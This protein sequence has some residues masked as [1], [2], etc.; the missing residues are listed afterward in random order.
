MAIWI[1]VALF[2]VLGF[3]G[4]FINKVPGPICVVIGVLI[5]KV[6]KD[7]P[8]SWATIALIAVLAIFS[9]F[10]AKKLV[11][12]VKSAQDYSKRAAIGTTLGS[13]I[14]LGL[15]LNFK[16]SSTITLIGIAAVALILVPFVLAL[17][18]E[19]TSKERKGTAIQCATAATGAYLCDTFLK[20]VV[21]VLAVFMVLD[22]M[23]E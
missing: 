3:L 21:F 10:A 5:A 8:V 17:L 23:I 4:C 18:L 14:G 15:M 16:S 22:N 19:L 7:L 6:A 13:I 9:L 11:Q 12:A 1:I 2:F 20:L